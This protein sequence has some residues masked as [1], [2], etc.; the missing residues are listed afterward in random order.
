M[1]TNIIFKSK[2]GAVLGNIYDGVLQLDYS[3][4]QLQPVTGT[5]SCILSLSPR[6]SNKTL[7]IAN[8]SQ[9]LDGLYTINGIK[10]FDWNGQFDIYGSACTSIIQYTDTSDPQAL[11]SDSHDIAIFDGCYPCPICQ[12]LAWVQNQIQNNQIWLKGMKDV[13]LYYQADAAGRW[14]D[15]IAS[16]LSNQNPVQC[17]IKPT[18]IS[19]DRGSVFG[20]AIKLLYQ[21]R[22]AVAMWN[23]LVRTKAAHIQIVSAPQDFSGFIVQTKLSIDTC[24]IAQGTSTAVDL[25]IDAVLQS[26]Q[27][28]TSNSYSWINGGYLQSGNLG[29][30]IYAD[31]TKQNT[32]IQYGKDTGI[33]TLQNLDDN[34]Q[35]N[36]TEVVYQQNGQIAVHTKL[37]FT[38]SKQAKTILSGAF[39]ILP[40]LYI[41]GQTYPSQTGS[42]ASNAHVSPTETVTRLS[43]KEWIQE[44]A[45]ATNI[46][47]QQ[48]DLVNVWHIRVKWQSPAAIAKTMQQNLYYFAAFGR[49][50]AVSQS[51]SLSPSGQ[52]ETEE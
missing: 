29:M 41:K 12:Q 24:G 34:I 28:D 47:S 16:K 10:P 36:G 38:P 44:R 31:R 14:Q 3:S 45:Y 49:Y 5:D 46:T 32:Y 51:D 1:V 9:S 11:A 13:N 4:S 43:L 48:Q 20:K 39:K 21:Y 26:G 7:S 50:P 25:T 27:C 2:S 33:H 15:E 52:G 23:F 35:S 18:S 42:D 40:V 22:Q 37:T 17:Y 30:G 6:Y 8:F 19:M